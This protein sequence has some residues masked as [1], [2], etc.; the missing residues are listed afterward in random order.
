[1]IDGQSKH[2]LEDVRRHLSF[3]MTHVHLGLP[4]LLTDNCTDRLP[5]PSPR[6]VAHC[7]FL[8]STPLI[9]K[10]PFRAFGTAWYFI[11]HRSIFPSS[12][13]YFYRR[14]AVGA[15]SPH[16][17]K[18]PDSVPSYPCDSPRGGASHVDPRSVRWDGI[19]PALGHWGKIRD[20]GALFSR[21]CPGSRA[22][23]DCQSVD[24]RSLVCLGQRC[25]DGELLGLRTCCVLPFWCMQQW[26][27]MR[28]AA[29]ELAELALPPHLAMTLPTSVPAWAH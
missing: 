18:H 20:G 28:P 2:G 7:S 5:E 17:H 25:L 16:L 26:H 8:N 9:R 12:D 29:E 10:K 21:R 11:K 13:P 1:M 24:L 22:V 6:S 27:L 3:K 15:Q 23:S 14:V 4:A 19:C